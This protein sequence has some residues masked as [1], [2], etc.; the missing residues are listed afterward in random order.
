VSFLGFYWVN[1]RLVRPVALWR[2][3]IGLEF[4]LSMLLGALGVFSINHAFILL[5]F[6]F[7]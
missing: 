1:A 3:A 5:F 4:L 2:R 7:R 6:N